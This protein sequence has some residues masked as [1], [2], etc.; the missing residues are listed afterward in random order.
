MR[1]SDK[2]IVPHF[3]LC[4]VVLCLVP[5]GF[6]GSQSREALL[7][8]ARV[9][10]VDN[11]D[12]RRNLVVLTGTQDVQVELLEGPQRGEQ[13][14]VVNPLAGKLE[15]DEVYRPGDTILVEYR[16]HQG[17]V[18]MAFARGYYRDIISL[19]PRYECIDPYSEIPPAT[20]A[21]CDVFAALINR[22][23]T[24]DLGRQGGF[25]R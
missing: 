11:A 20:T 17:R 22:N 24:C 15:F 16:L 10:S 3:L 25:K 6:E 21:F 19:L 2:I 23:R 5:T 8:K 13:A 1:A 14:R 7:A 9:L 4:C 12:L 18:H